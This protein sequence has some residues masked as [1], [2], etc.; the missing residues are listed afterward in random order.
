MILSIYKVG[1]LNRWKRSKQTFGHSGITGHPKSAAPDDFNSTRAAWTQLVG[2]GGLSSG[3]FVTMGIRVPFIIIFVHLFPKDG[4][5]SLPKIIERAAIMICSLFPPAFLRIDHGQ[6][7]TSWTE[8]EVA[9]GTSSTIEPP[10]SVVVDDIF[11]TAVVP[12]FTSRLF[13][14]KRLVGTILSL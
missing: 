5:S 3:K 14:I 7:M 13:V 4:I 9:A 1:F 2:L 8:P 10:L 6:T 11:V 12:G